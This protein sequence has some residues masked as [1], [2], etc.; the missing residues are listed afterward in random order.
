M[1]GP[2]LGGRDVDGTDR[3]VGDKV[4]REGFK[5]GR[6]ISETSLF[7]QTQ[8][9]CLTHPIP[10]ILPQEKG[11]RLFGGWGQSQPL[12]WDKKMSAHVV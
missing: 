8:G 12:Q 7:L 2:S 3:V 6:K 9:K 1:P 11:K 10:H 4:D 5:N